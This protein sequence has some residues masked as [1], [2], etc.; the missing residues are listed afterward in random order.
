MTSKPASIKFLAIGR[1]ITPSPMKPTVAMVSF[2]TARSEHRVGDLKA[3]GVA[4]P[5]HEVSLRVVG[6]VS[7]SVVGVA[8]CSLEYV[9]S[10]AHGAAACVLHQQIHGADAML[11]R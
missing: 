2:T 9:V 5:Q 4:P 11:C 8:P 3:E 7:T 10:T 1:P 6:D